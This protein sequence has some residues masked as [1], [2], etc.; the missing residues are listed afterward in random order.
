M[1]RKLRTPKTRNEEISETAL[2]V[3]GD[4]RLYPEP[5]HV[6]PW[7]LLTNPA[8]DYPTTDYI[9][10]KAL[11]DSCSEMILAEWIRKYPGT[12]PSWWWLFDAPRML[13]ADLEAN[14]W[15]PCYFAKELPDPRARLGGIGTPAHEVL[16]YV[17]SFPC[18]IPDSWVDQWS[19]D[20]YNGRAVDIHGDS[21]GQDH[22]EGD[23]SGVPIDPS[24]PPRFESQASYL[25]RHGLFM[26]GEEK[27][28][29][30]DAFEPEI[31]QPG[32]EE[33]EEE[34]SLPESTGGLIQ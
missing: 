3:M 14:D 7:E 32:P 25:R 11:W 26:P 12:R 16:A 1:P 21:I 8:L 23:F 24:D 15:R 30:K 28:L 4:R 33:E 6:N 9:A 29:P 31:I 34:I 22:K 19:T 2:W 18:G 27:R 20:Y 13:K 5:E 17:P 10:C